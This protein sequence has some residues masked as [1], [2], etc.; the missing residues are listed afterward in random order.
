MTPVATG[1]GETA[2]HPVLGPGEKDTGA[3]GA[4]TMLGAGPGDVLA[5]AHARPAAAQETAVFPGEDV[6]VHIGLARKHPALTERPE[7]GLER[8]RI[9]GR[10][11]VLAEANRAVTLRVAVIGVQAWSPP[12]GRRWRGRLWEWSTGVASFPVRSVA[13]GGAWCCRFSSSPS[14]P[15]PVEPPP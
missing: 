12:H 1:V 6:V 5:P 13:A 3:T 14:A 7:R 4:A 8:H 2:H 15:P 10:S 9:N 11:V